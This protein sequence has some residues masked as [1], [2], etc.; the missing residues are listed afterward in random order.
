MLLRN[1]SLSMIWFYG[2]CLGGESFGAAKGDKDGGHVIAADA[3]HGIGSYQSFEEVLHYFFDFLFLDEFL[4][5]DIYDS[6][7]VF[8]IV[9]PYPVAS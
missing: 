2:W 4:F 8:N 3:A 7:V 5:Y 9:L 6:L 1:I